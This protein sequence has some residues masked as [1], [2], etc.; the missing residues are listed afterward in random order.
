MC[1]H[2]LAPHC[3]C[4]AVRCVEVVLLVWSSEV[5]AKIFEYRHAWVLRLLLYSLDTPHAN[6]PVLLTPP[7]GVSPPSSSDRP[8]WLPPKLWLGAALPFL[9]TIKLS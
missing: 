5:Q 1:V 2:V 6:T 3:N 9:V 8:P 4:R 7:A